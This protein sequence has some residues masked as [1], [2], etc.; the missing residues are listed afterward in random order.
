[1]ECHATMTQSKTVCAINCRTREITN[2]IVAI[3]CQS[4]IANIS[5]EIFAYTSIKCTCMHRKKIPNCFQ[6]RNAI[7]GQIPFMGTDAKT[8]LVKLL[9]D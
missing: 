3:Q 1:M 9:D 7:Q 4:E 5:I 6:V 8:H 2:H